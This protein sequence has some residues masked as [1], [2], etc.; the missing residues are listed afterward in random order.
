MFTVR[1]ASPIGSIPRTVT[2]MP[3]GVSTLGRLTTVNP[4]G[5]TIGSPSVVV[6]MPGSRRMI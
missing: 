4:S 1:I 3:S 2:F 5:E 6:A